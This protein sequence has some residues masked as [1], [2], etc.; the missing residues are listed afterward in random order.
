MALRGNVSGVLDSLFKSNVL[1]AVNK[2][3]MT[4]KTKRFIKK[5]INLTHFSEICMN[6]KDK[7]QRWYRY[8]RYL[9]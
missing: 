2:V 9:D 8:Y 4:V 7:N 1:Q 3:D 5:I 6:L